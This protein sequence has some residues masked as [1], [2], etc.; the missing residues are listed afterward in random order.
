MATLTDA[1]VYLRPGV[2]FANVDGTLG[3]VRWETPGVTPPTADEVAAAVAH[4]DNP[5][6]P[7]VKAGQLIRALD[8]LGLLATV[9]AA[10]AQADPLTQRLWARA[11]TFPRNDPLLLSFAQSIGKTSADLDNIFRLAATK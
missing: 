1:L 6:P 5:V 11:S 2:A 9:D 4:L 10:V 3:A 7:E 8:E